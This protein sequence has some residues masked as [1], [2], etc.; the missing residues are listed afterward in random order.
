MTL[1]AIFWNRHTHMQREEGQWE[2][3]S[4]W[5]RICVQYFNTHVYSYTISLTLMSNE[6]TRTRHFALKKKKRSCISTKHQN[7]SAGSLS[8]THTHTH[9]QTHTYAHTHTHTHTH[10]EQQ[11]ITI[12]FSHYHYKEDL[13]VYY[14]FRQWAHEANTQQVWDRQWYGATG[15]TS[16]TN[17]LF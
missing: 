13:T 17:K 9:A 14:L 10:A 2:A 4:L 1:L 11:S 12:S 16:W 7:N 5:D 3:H 6:M 15:L 8:H